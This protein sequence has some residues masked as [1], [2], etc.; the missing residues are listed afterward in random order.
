MYSFSFFSEVKIRQLD[1]SNDDNL[2]LKLSS[3]SKTLNYSNQRNK[4]IALSHGTKFDEHVMGCLTC[5]VRH[6]ANVIKVPVF[7][8]YIETVALPL[9]YM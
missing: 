3:V 5:D 1:A 4:I 6:V 8:M 9:Q 7:A 2:R